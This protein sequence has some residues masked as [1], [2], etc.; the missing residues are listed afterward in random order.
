MA[1]FALFGCKMPPLTWL[2]WKPAR[3]LHP[4]G[5]AGFVERVVLADVEVA[6]VLLLRCSGRDG[7]ERHAAKEGD[8][9]V[10]FKAMKAEEPALFTG[11]IEGRVPFYRLAHVRDGAGD[12][13]VEAAADVA[14]PA[15]HG[16]DIGLH[17]R[18]AVSLGDLR[19]A[20][21]KQP[22]RSGRR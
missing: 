21:R 20:A 10:F 16:G 17:G 3:L 13:G 9:Y 14:F 1:G 22:G 4:V 12:E 11:A 2:A 5:E 6:H 15:W 8:F 19:V 7:F 18:F